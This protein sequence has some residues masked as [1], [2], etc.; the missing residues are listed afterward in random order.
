MMKTI[1]NFSSFCTYSEFGEHF[2]RTIFYFK[3]EFSDVEFF[4]CCCAFFLSVSLSLFLFYCFIFVSLNSFSRTNEIIM[5][6]SN[7]PI[8]IFC[9]LFVSANA[10]AITSM[11]DSF[12][13]DLFLL[14]YS[15]FTVSTRS[16]FSNTFLHKER[17]QCRKIRI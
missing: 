15:L 4:P 8:I 9:L 16:A 14:L 13:V 5:Q 10:V 12:V 3:M 6:I 1:H 2:K 17:K 7:L 11:H